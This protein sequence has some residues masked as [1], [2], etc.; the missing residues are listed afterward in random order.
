MGRLVDALRRRLRSPDRG[1]PPA[2]LPGLES[3]EEAAVAAAARADEPAGEPAEPGSHGDA[4][5]RI[6]AARER[7]RATIEPPD[8]DVD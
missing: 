5:A 3:G 7:L 2:T 4:A 6:D 1:A 8:P